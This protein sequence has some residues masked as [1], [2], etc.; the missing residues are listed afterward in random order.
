[1]TFGCL[2]LVLSTLFPDFNPETGA[3]GLGDKAY[4]LTLLSPL[5]G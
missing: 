2:G 3:W 4:F 5:A 1:V